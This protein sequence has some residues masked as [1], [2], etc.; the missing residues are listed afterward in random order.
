M[1]LEKPDINGLDLLDF[2]SPEAIY[3]EAV[4]NQP[5]E[6]INLLQYQSAEYRLKS[7]KT[8]FYPTLTFAYNI[9]S[10]YSNLIQNKPFNKW[11]DEFGNQVSQNFNQI[12]GVI[13]TV[14]IFSNG[15]VQTGYRQ[16]KLK[17]QSLRLDIQ[18]Y[19]NVLKQNVYLA[20]SNL[21]GA[22]RKLNESRK[23]V[24]EFDKTYEISN[25]AFNLGSLN[26][27]DLINTQNELFKVK[28]SLLGSSLDYFLKYQ[29]LQ[30]YR[31]GT[32]K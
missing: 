18:E 4:K 9:S 31:N 29:I 28:E 2:E 14:P 3:L 26:A 20:Y 32:M 22:Y 6:K 15:Q 30:F 16:N 17:L 25:T 5:R 23:T 10:L 11:F 12:V 21:F 24:I 19:G 8:A 13:V 27:Q 7:S 1:K